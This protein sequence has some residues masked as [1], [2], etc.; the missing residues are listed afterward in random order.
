MKKF[1]QREYKRRWAAATRSLK[2]QYREPLVESDS[3][4][5]MDQPLVLPN[6]PPLNT[7]PLEAMTD[8]IT[9]A[10]T[11][12]DVQY[13]ADDDRIWDVINQ[14]QHTTPLSDS[15]EEIEHDCFEDQLAIWATK[16]Q[17]KHIAL[18]GLL[19]LLKESGHPDLP[20]TAR[21]LLHTAR[22]VETHLRSGM[23]YY[24]FGVEK[25]LLKHFQMY[26]VETR[27]HT[28]TL[29]ISLNIDGLQPFKS[30]PVSMW[31]VLCSIVNMKPNVVFPLVLTY[32]KSKPTDLEFLSDVIQDLKRILEH[33][34]Q[35]GD[36]SIQVTIKCI[37]CDAPARAMV[38]NVKL[39]AGYAECDKCGQREEYFGRSRTKK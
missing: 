21:T 23:E 11:V 5:D 33:G 20:K 28:G 35:N 10:C 37:V 29:E 31:P 39:F 34:L 2:K 6:A 13:A 24:Y 9:G 1:R 27:R 16:H 17:I 14:F 36:D 19:K 22:E 25:E 30:S 4:L 7:V 3:E 15:E 32:G 38:K 8:E 18:D 26:P 12:Q